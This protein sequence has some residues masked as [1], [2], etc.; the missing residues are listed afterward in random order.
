VKI[1]IIS[2]LSK[3]QGKKIDVLIFATKVM[4]LRS[5]VSQA[6]GLDPKYVLLPQNGLF[7]ISWIK[8]RFKKATVCRGVTTMACQ[9]SALD[10]VTLLY[11]GNFY[12][13][14]KGSALVGGV[15]RKAGMNVMLC[16]DP[17]RAVWAKLIFSASMNPLPVMTGQGYEV[18]R[19]DGKIWRLVCNAVNEGRAVSRILGV[20]LA[21][22]PLKLVQRVRS[23]DLAGIAYRGSMANDVLLGHPTEIDFITGALVRQARQVKVKTP[24]LDSIL[25][26]SKL[27]GA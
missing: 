13:G 24:A 21:F 2:S 12:I 4:D 27:A 1:R 18:L 26:R 14:G 6:A 3:I 19:T 22:D 11:R 25:L 10:E 9:E 20:R 8:R 16:K 7:D 17:R 23:G 5:A 15:L